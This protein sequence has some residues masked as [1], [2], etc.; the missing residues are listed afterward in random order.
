MHILQIPFG[1]GDRIR[2]NDTPGMNPRKSV[3]KPKSYYNIQ[4]ES[5][6]AFVYRFVQERMTF[7]HAFRIQKRALDKISFSDYNDFTESMK[8]NNSM[9][10]ETHAE[11]ESL[12]EN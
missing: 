12:P 3:Q 8:H 6:R 7:P 5:G 1:T 9:K 11:S 4:I 10:G 2:T